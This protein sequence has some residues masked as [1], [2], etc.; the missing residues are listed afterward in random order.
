MVRHVFRNR[1]V[2]VDWLMCCADICE[3]GALLQTS[4]FVVFDR[5][6]DSLGLGGL[7]DMRWH[8]VWGTLGRAHTRL[9]VAP[10]FLTRQYKRN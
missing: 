1:G 8:T 7:C 5:C 10:P 6:N 9:W 4:V 2:Y 3:C